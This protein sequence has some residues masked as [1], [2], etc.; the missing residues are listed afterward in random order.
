MNLST[1]IAAVIIIVLFVLASRYLYKNGT[2][3]SCPDRG[4]CHG[5]CSTDKIKKDPMYKEKSKKIDEL[6]KK[7]G[8]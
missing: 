1:I 7:H 4:S 6:M 3:G 2:C 8:F 5:H